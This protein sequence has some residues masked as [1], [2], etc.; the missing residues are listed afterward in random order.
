[1]L[2]G[3]LLIP[4]LQKAG[5]ATTLQLLRGW[6]LNPGRRPSGARMWGLHVLLPLIPNLLLACTLKPVLGRTRR[7]LK[8]YMPDS[9]WVAMICGGSALAWTVLRTGLVLATLRRRRSGPQEGEQPMAE[10]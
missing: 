7:Y 4:A 5:I 8:L 1:M 9:Y 3:Q 6:R 10:R 2:R